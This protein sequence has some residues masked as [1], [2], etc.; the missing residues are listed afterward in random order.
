M[1]GPRPGEVNREYAAGIA[2]ALANGW[3][4]ELERLERIKKFEHMQRAD[5]Q[6]SW[7]WVHYMLHGSPETKGILLDYLHDL[8][9]ESDPAPLSQRLHQ[10]Q[11]EYAVRFLSY[12]ATVNSTQ[13]LAAEPHVLPGRA[14]L[15]G[16]SSV[17]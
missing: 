16:R 11:P 2:T 9:K 5:Y 1:I 6:E 13:M 14:E 7:A 3:R 12:A 17:R 15:P 4:P 8:R 10:D